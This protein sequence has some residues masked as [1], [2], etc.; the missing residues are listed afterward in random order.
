MDEFGSSMIQVVRSIPMAR[1]DGG[2]GSQSANGGLVSLSVNTEGALKVSMTG[3]GQYDPTITSNGELLTSISYNGVSARVQVPTD[4]LVASTFW[5]L[6]V[7]AMQ[8]QYN[9][10]TIER[11]YSNQ[12]ITA[13]SSAARTATTNSASLTNRN[14]QGAHFI[15]DVTA[16][17]AT[18]SITPTIQGY[19]DLSGK[20]YDL[21]V[22]N[23]ISAVGTNILKIHP[24][25]TGVANAA[26]NDI[27]PRT[28]RISMAHADA[29]SI[30]YSVGVNLVL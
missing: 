3:S 7:G 19:D 12:N 6:N 10:S 1:L 11:V 26:A 15:I 8:L 5:A 17:T 13:L 18:P 21:L 2:E 9:G 22:G 29:D 20:W 30:T 28:Y 23:A 24:G 14:F 16:I 4:S 25:I 27:L